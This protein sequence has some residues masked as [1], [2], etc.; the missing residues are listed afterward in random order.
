MLSRA[1]RQV[2]AVRGRTSF[3]GVG[4]LRGG[5]PGPWGGGG[6][7][8][9]R[10]LPRPWSR[11]W[12]SPLIGRP[13]RCRRCLIRYTVPNATS[14]AS[15]TLGA[16]QPSLLLRRIRALAVTRAELFPTRIRFWS[17]SR[18]SGANRTAYLSLIITA[19]PNISTSSPAVYDYQ[20]VSCMTF[21]IK[22]D[23]LRDHA[24][25]IGV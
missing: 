21:N 10:V 25:Y 19:T 9:D 7:G 12:R 8:R 14:R 18:C 23:S 6:C 22:V 13:G 17:S 11:W 5:C 4:P 24:L 3:A 15:A 1:A 20:P 16:A 2:H